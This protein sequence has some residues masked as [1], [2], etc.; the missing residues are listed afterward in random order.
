MENKDLLNPGSKNPEKDKDQGVENL[1][2]QND[3]AR[4][5][6][7]ESLET[8][9][10]TIEV[11]S[12]QTTEEKET[13]GETSD[14]GASDT[15]GASDKKDEQQPVE[16]QKQLNQEE[17][18]SEYASP[19]E[20]E[21]ESETPDAENQADIDQEIKPKYPESADIEQLEQNKEEKSSEEKVNTEEP[22][23]PLVSEKTKE[24]Q[25]SK[26]ASEK[27]HKE[28]LSQKKESDD[29]A[30]K[31]Q[32]ISQGTVEEEEDENLSEKYGSL[33]KQELVEAL[34]ALLEK[35]DIA[36]IRKHIGYIK[37]AFR[38]IV[39]SEN[40]ESYEKNISSSNEKEQEEKIVTDELSERFDKAFALYKQ[41]KY[42]YDQAFE[43]QKEDNLKA[44]EALLED[45]R[46]LIESEE[47]LKRTYDIFKE[48]QDK[49]R[50]IGPV[51]QASKNTLWNNYHFLVEKFFDKV[52]INKELRDLDLKKNLESKTELC[53]KAEE[54]LLEPSINKSFEK[55][56]KL[57]EAW[58]ETGPAPKDKKD[59]IWERFKA[60]SD[61]LNERRQ[62]YYDNLREEQNKNYA[63]KIVLC[64]K[65]E[66]IASETP[67][68]PKNW[69]GNTDKINELFKVWKTIG[70]APKK[71]N[72]E[73]WVRFRTALDKFFKAKK[74]FFSN[75]KDEQNENYNQKLHICAQA[76]AL[77]DSEDWKKT[78]DELITLQQ[79]WK[80]IGPVPRKVSDKIW[81]RFRGAC[82]EF[83]NRK[84]AYFANIG[85]KQEENL[86]RKKELI[87][88]IRIYEYTDDKSKNLDVLKDFQR[89]WM[90][91]GHVPI[92]EKD[93]IQNEFRK[94]INDQFDK[95]NISRKAQSTIGFKNKIESLKNSPNADNII[96]KER[97]FLT[98][99]INTLQNDIKLWENNIGFFASSKK[100][101]VL[102]AEFEKK[103][104]K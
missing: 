65:A 38:T 14:E 71:V 99:K 56:Q 8:E 28:N 80:K 52:K 22:T 90:E 45:L 84:S 100:A 85:E 40:M 49:W 48:L 31:E 1:N 13:A 10:K 44:K 94:T 15:E 32:K 36:F 96:H 54:L 93:R 24:N 55:L 82:D 63:A 21:Q 5:S 30:N 43:K 23:N 25:V 57:H 62:K 42:V 17:K 37:I 74:E 33:N 12:E 97:N 19:K 78:T 2:Q 58:K 77:K 102:K 67:K 89:Q 76:E 35:D 86:I 88:K 91:I 9:K 51:P 26:E 68:T 27:K 47:E 103:I 11:S 87:E 34:E 79:Q 59:Q 16:N 18:A 83:F 4:D 70:F 20:K 95:L 81:K 73:I 41:K 104:E 72:D 50:E 64:E 6:E 53:E 3:F 66:E 101:D 39:K 60:A 92:K 7:S 46:Q 61:A 29:E 69:Q 98:G 75:Y